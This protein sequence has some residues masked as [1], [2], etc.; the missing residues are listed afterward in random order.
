VLATF[1]FLG[2]PSFVIGFKLNG[3][4]N[5]G[6]FAYDEKIR[7]TAELLVFIPACIWIGISL[8]ILVFQFV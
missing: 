8:I 5:D 6:T 3:K 1:L 4:N 2:I 7:K